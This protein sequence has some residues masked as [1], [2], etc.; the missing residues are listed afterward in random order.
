MMDSNFKKLR[1]V[2]SFV[3]RQGRLTQGQQLALD[4]GWQQF[5]LKEDMEK[6]N[7]NAV[8]NREGFKGLE[9]GFGDGEALI[10]TILTHPDQDWIGI[11]V[12]RPGVGHLI[13]A[14]QTA[15]VSN[16]RVANR[17]ALE[18]LH[19]QIADDSLDE[20]RLFFPDPW[21]KTRHHKR[22]IVQADFV[23][24]IHRVLKMGGIFHMATD[25]QAY[26]SH[27]QSVM[28]QTT[29]FEEEKMYLGQSHTPPVRKNTKFERRGRNLGHKTWDLLYKKTSV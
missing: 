6:L 7:L 14:A 5:A 16:V 20:V 18:V 10:D 23:A 8:F 17:D 25:W 15:E 29:G 19:H 24:E 2:R 27:M 13:M 1:T 12:H 11:E 3:R 9:I 26:A 4:S 21:H 28:A 22:R